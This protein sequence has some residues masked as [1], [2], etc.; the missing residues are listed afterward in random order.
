IIRDFEALGHWVL[1]DL[2]D[3]EAAPSVSPAL[4][5]A[6]VRS[7]RSDT[8]QRMQ[9]CLALFRRKS[10]PL[11][12]LLHNSSPRAR[13]QGSALQAEHILQYDRLG[14]VL[15]GVIERLTDDEKKATAN[16]MACEARDFLISMFTDTS[17]LTPAQVDVGTAIVTKAIAETNIGDWLQVVWSFDNVT[18]QHCLLVAGLAAAFARSLG[19]SER[20]SR[21]LT[22]A[23]LLHDIGKVA[24]PVA[25]LNKPSFLTK[26]EMLV[27]RTH[28]AHGHAM[29]Q[30]R[31]FE[32]EMLQVV[33]SHHE[34]L[35]GSGYP[36]GLAGSQIPDVVRLVTI[37]DIYAALIERRPYKAPM[38][39]VRAY[40]ILKEMSGR[41]D[42]DLVRA[43]E[44]I[45][46]AFTPI[47]KNGHAQPA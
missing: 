41:L 20:D 26:D 29:L 42:P 22:K 47:G 46:Q 12:W 40:E 9:K 35:D 5:V 45:A 37:C 33:R 24:V 2:W 25:I 36:D 38:S 32:A 15:P 10:L 16:A 18:H 27:M 8:L 1:F 44:P 23:A 4:I 19:M 17:A 39:M 31:G 7:P 34:M 11:L 6:D 14:L 30:G 13:I 21:H 3:D 28:A 43:F